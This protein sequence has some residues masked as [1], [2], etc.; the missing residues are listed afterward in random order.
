MSTAPLLKSVVEGDIPRIRVIREAVAPILANNLL[1]HFTDHSVTH[2]DRLV[3]L[4]AHLVRIM[5]RKQRLSPDESFI[6]QAACYC[7]DLGMQYEQAGATPVIGALRLATPWGRLDDAARKALLRD[8][9]HEISAQLV[10]GIVPRLPSLLPDDWRRGC[11]AALCEAHAL[12]I[13]ASRYSDL[14]KPVAGARMALLAGLLRVADILDESQRRVDDEK[15]ASLLLDT[16]TQ[17]HWWRHRYT[18]E[19]LL[20]QKSRNIS[21]HFVFPAERLQEYAAIVPHIQVPEIANEISRHTS[22]FVDAGLNWGVTYT[23]TS[24]PY[25]TAPQMPDAVLAAM[26]LLLHKKRSAEAEER[27]LVVARSFTEA[28]PHIDRIIRDLQARKDAIPAEEYIHGLHDISKHMRSLGAK[29]SAWSLLA[30]EFHRA[31]ASLS[32]A[33][34]VDVANWLVGV[35]LEDACPREALEPAGVVARLIPRLKTDDKLVLLRA[36]TAAFSANA[37]YQQALEPLTKAIRLAPDEAEMRATLAELHLLHGNVHLARHWDDAGSDSTPAACRSVMAFAKARAMCA[38]SPA[39]LRS[40]DNFLASHREALAASDRTALEMLKAQI[41][42]LD[43]E[44]EAA[45]ACFPEGS[46]GLSDQEQMVLADNRSMLSMLSWKLDEAE[47]A[48]LADQRRLLGVQLWRPECVVAGYDAA[49][50]NKHWDALPEYWQEYVRTFQLHCWNSHRWAAA[51]LA[52]ELMTLGMLDDAAHYCLLAEDD[53]TTTLLEEKAAEVG[54]SKQASEIVTRLLR[55]AHLLRHAAVAARILTAMADLIVDEQVDRALQWVR[56]LCRVV[57]EKWGIRTAVFKHAWAFVSALVP[58]LPRG[59][60]LECAREA[61]SHP[62][63]QSPHVLRGHLIEAVTACAAFVPV[64]AL[65]ALAS[66]ALPLALEKKSDLDFRDIVNLLCQIAHRCSGTT[67]LRLR[68][69]LYPAGQTQSSVYLAQVSRVFWGETP[70]LKNIPQAAV[71]VAKNIRLWVQRLP[72]GAEPEPVNCS[73]GS[74][75]SAPGRVRTVVQMASGADLGV[76][77]RNGHLLPRGS[78]QHLLQAMV[79]MLEDKDN[80]SGNKTILA[81]AMEGLSPHL[82][83]DECRSLWLPLSKLAAGDVGKRSVSDAQEL[84]NPLNPYKFGSGDLDQL[85]G[86]SL[87]ALATL[88]KDHPG[89]YGKKAITLVEKLLLH[90]NGDMRAW[91]FA[92]AGGLPNPSDLVITGVLL[93][94]HDRSDEAAKAAFAVIRHAL[95]RRLKKPHWEILVHSARAAGSAPDAGVRREV[96]RLVS[97][98]PGIASGS[99]EAFRSIRSLLLK[100][101]CW[102]V[103]QACRVGRR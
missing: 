51:R 10:S 19:V 49:A 33:C 99:R 94:T 71:S 74:H 62:V 79:A 87:R 16:A 38:G 3:S 8:H 34:Q 69:A 18:A 43:G 64:A 70:H 41:L 50:D 53:R 93:G 67:R 31:A 39:G 84:Q 29:R 96:A 82:D 65:D 5:D 68:K 92:A 21:L 46:V 56:P 32:P 42:V 83:Q 63:W 61:M 73:F 9:H 47:F 88:E 1:P 12:D 102:S 25:V 86:I 28:R 98:D 40:I 52:R 35:M 101:R 17:A 13:S 100:D 59:T 11:V 72:R 6:L 37:A 54:H 36:Q 4:L 22:A 58:R 85:S 24:A 75:S 81:G 78:R 90:E 97:T 2:S 77:V 80:T 95:T 45:C 89:I 27:K 20:D 60:V 15:A 23:V 26:Q 55:N 76:I 44:E 30:S 14:T 91:A 66:D 57:P 7:H 103:R 48:R